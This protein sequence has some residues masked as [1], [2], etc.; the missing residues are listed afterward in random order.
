MLSAKE[1]YKLASGTPVIDMQLYNKAMVR[2]EILILSKCD[3]HEI[4][5]RLPY[6]YFDSTN[7]YDLW[8]LFHNGPEGPWRATFKKIADELIKLGYIV[9]HDD[10][11]TYIQW[12]QAGQL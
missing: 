1:A 2:L 9:A 6:K 3:D 8:R 4:E 5:L 11:D 10:T 7:D 12:A